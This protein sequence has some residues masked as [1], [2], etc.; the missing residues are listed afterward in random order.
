MFRA[1]LCPSSGAD[2]LEVFVKFFVKLFVLKTEAVARQSP[3][4]CVCVCF[5][6]RCLTQ[7]LLSDV[8]TH[9]LT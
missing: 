2:D 5:G 8:H 6:N 3:C 4:V 1:T 9:T 7:Q